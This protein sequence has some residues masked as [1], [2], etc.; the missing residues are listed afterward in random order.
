LSWIPDLPD[1]GES[2]ALM[3]VFVIVS[4]AVISAILGHN[5]KRRSD[6]CEDPI[7]QHSTGQ[8]AGMSEESEDDD[9]E[10]SDSD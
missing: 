4:A 7:R 2:L 9:F 5:R 10:D 1:L 8:S 6:D 3:A